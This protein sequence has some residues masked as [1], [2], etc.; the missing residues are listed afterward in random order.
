MAAHTL[1]TFNFRIAAVAAAA[2]RTDV[3]SR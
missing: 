1:P 3:L 2:A